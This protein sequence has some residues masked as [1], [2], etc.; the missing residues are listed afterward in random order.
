MSQS[1]HANFKVFLARA[2]AIEQWLEKHEFKAY[3]PF[4]GLNSF[5]R[6][7]A[8]SNL[9]AERVLEQIVKRS[10]VNLR[11]LLGIKPE[12]STKGMGF[13]AWG[14]FYMYLVTRDTDYKEKALRW[15]DWLDKNKAPGYEH[16]SW[17]NHFD[18][19]SRGGRQ[20]KNEPDIVWTGLLG[21]AYIDAYSEFVIERHRE[22]A[23]SILTWILRLP[24]EKTE[25]GICLSYLATTQ[26][27]IHNSNMVGAGYLARAGKLLG[28]LEAIEVAA[29]A[30]KYSC[31]RQLP[32]GSWYYGESTGNHWID[33]FHTAY[34]L[35]SLK[36]F[37][38]SLGDNTYEENLRKGFEF[39]KKNLFEED[40]RPKYY[41]NRT[42][43]IDSQCCSQ[44]IDTLANFAQYDRD[45]LPLGC[46]VADWTIRRM[47]DP[48]GHIYFRRYLLG[49]KIKTPMLHWAQTTTFKAIAHLIWK[50]KSAL[51]V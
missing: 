12:T 49:I 35:D 45:A 15:L 5:V 40:G 7:L 39:Y 19:V 18:H 11:P 50:L 30:M 46:K 20:P 44:A 47:Q 51:K 24:R 43:P 28:K 27:S 31:S 6:P 42:L 3:D 33:N 32:D 29:E 25:C 4:D 26:S 21:H 36:C 22:V 9:F 17:G 41:H 13:M 14:C 2:Q 10:P 34:N 48:D 1:L 8:F 16:H 38:E 37:I 23:E